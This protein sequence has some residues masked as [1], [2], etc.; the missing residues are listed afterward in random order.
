MFTRNA[1]VSL[2]MQTAV[3]LNVMAPTLPLDADDAIEAPDVIYLDRQII[4]NYHLPSNLSCLFFGS[5]CN[6]SYR[7]HVPLR[8]AIKN[9][10]YS[11]N[12]VNIEALLPN[13]DDDIKRNDHTFVFYRNQDM[14]RVY[15]HVFYSIKVN[16]S[17]FLNSLLLVILFR[18]L[19]LF[20]LIHIFFHVLVRF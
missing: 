9:P 12:N 8:R 13:D 16:C 4:A 1:R 17:S 19:I 18:M 2:F 20:H 11:L 15:Y 5:H 3:N 10:P 7:L 14:R 6:Q